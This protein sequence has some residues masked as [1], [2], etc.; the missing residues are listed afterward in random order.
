MSSQKSTASFKDRFIQL[1]GCGSKH[2]AELNGSPPGSPGRPRDD[3]EG[4]RRGLKRQKMVQ[5][6]NQRSATLA[7]IPGRGR[8]TNNANDLESSL[9]R[10]SVSSQRLELDPDFI[11]D[12]NLEASGKLSQSNID[13][14]KK[15]SKKKP[16]AT[17]DDDNYA[18]Q[19]KSKP[20]D[21]SDKKKKSEKNTEQHVKES[22]LESVENNAKIENLDKDIPKVHLGKN[23]VDGAIKTKRNPVKARKDKD[24]AKKATKD[25]AKQTKD[26]DNVSRKSSMESVRLIEDKPKRKKKR[27]KSN[28]NDIGIEVAP[29]HKSSRKVKNRENVEFATP[30]VPVKLMNEMNW[31]SE[32]EIE[33]NGNKKVKRWKGRKKMSR[34][35]LRNVS[36]TQ[37]IIMS[38]VFMSKSRL[39]FFNLYPKK[40]QKYKYPCKYQ[41]AL[42]VW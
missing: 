11:Q 13:T 24:A 14:K 23:E 22:L 37:N 36:Q 19:S 5:N 18:I 10:T 20:K 28:E 21:K 16:K 40:I 35:L 3:F 1:F 42:N 12:Y 29:V 32:E 6:P 34:E 27:S 30:R 41:K 25:N 7:A 39:W 38:L 26:Q 33:Q 15:L 9:R 2:Q 8:R 31:E 4:S 17:K